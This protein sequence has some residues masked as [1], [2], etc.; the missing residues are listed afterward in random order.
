MIKIAILTISEIPNIVQ[1]ILGPKSQNLPK[2]VLVKWGISEFPHC[3]VIL[4]GVQNEVHWI[5]INLRARS[6]WAN[7]ALLYITQSLNLRKIFLHVVNVIF[8]ESGHVFTK[9]KH[10]QFTFPNCKW[11]HI[12]IHKI[13][14]QNWFDEKFES[15]TW[16]ECRIFH[17]RTILRYNLL[18][19][20]TCLEFHLPIHRNFT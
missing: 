2:I 15:S 19:H 11:F 1:W 20:F 9:K 6:A 10:Q 8:S 4:Q 3:E 18:M 14:T 16:Y 17:F 12:K 13:Q 7:F 5:Y